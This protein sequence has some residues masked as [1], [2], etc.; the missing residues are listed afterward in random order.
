[1]ED[2]NQLTVPLFELDTDGS[3]L[4]NFIFHRT[5]DH[6]HAR[7]IEYPWVASKYRGEA[8]ILDI[9][10]AKSN[11]QWLA[12]LESLEA[13]VTLV[14]LD[15]P[16]I[17]LE[18]IN[19]VNA[20]L[21]DLPF[22]DDTFDVVFSVSVIEHVGLPSPQ[23]NDTSKIVVDPDG[24]VRAIEELIRVLRPG[25]RILT[26]FP[27]ANTSMLAF[28]NQARVYDEAEL[29]RFESVAH[30]ASDEYYQYVA[31][32]QNKHF[33]QHT[34]VRRPRSQSTAQQRANNDGVLCAEF[35][36]K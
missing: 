30:L 18:R 31:R 10:S 26:T 11:W 15:E 22:D 2:W 12:W 7:C 33:G 32:A 14:D 24:D 16:S 6:V 35:V 23:V 25:G 5:W 17:P 8:D 19:Y 4:P 34:W 28:G 27:F 9:G 13:S 21:L 36:S 20:N 1:M 3:V 29:K